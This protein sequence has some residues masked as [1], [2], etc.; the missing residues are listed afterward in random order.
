MTNKLINTYFKAIYQLSKVKI[1]FAV[2]L[3][4][5][6][7]YLLAKQQLTF[8]IILPSLGIFLLACGSSV[9][10]HIQ[11]MKYDKLMKRT[12]GR[13]LPNGSV[14][15]TTAV[16]L[17]ILYILPGVIILYFSAGKMALI[18]GMTALFWYNIIYTPLKK[19]TANAVIPGSVIGSIPPLVGWVSAGKSLFY[20]QP[21][22]MACFFFVWQVPHFY[23]LALKYGKEYEMAGLPTLTQSYSK[24]Q[25]KLIIFIWVVASIIASL[26]VPV[27][28][29]THS[30]TTLIGVII[31]CLWLFI[32]F[33]RFLRLPFE[34]I[35]PFSYFMK[36][37]YFVLWMILFYSLDFIFIQMET[38]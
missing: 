1:T 6:C 23:L 35:R 10:N 34:Q 24:K 37:N 20:V 12:R 17:A 15:V 26:F 27:F 22:I 36:I 30:Y 5:I 16:I 38:Q 14:S 13:P 31:G 21:W 7:G 29:V 3:T 8:K 32:H 9:I 33:L 2:A 28:H 19:I 11:E 18:L 4:T 25:I